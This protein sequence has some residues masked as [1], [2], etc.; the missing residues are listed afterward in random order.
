MD[1]FEQKYAYILGIVCAVISCIA[2]AIISV[3]SRRLKT[4]HYAVIQFN[5]GV[6][7]STMNLLFLIF[8]CVA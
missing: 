6:L 2:Q 1:A 3:A 8:V 7:S 5:Y 4:I